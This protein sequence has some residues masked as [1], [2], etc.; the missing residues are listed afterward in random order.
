MARKIK[1]EDE[2][3]LPLMQLYLTKP[4]GVKPIY[5][6]ETVR[7][8]LDL[9][10]S[11][12]TLYKKMFLLRRL[13]TPRIER[14]WNTYSNSPQKLAKGVK[15]WRRMRGFNSA[16][17]FYEGV[18]VNESWEK[19]FKAIPGLEPLTP[20][21]L[22]LILDLYFRL[23]PITMNANTPEVAQLAKRMNIPASTV[24]QAMA[25]YQW[26]DPYLNRPTPPTQPLADA[27][28][29][30]WKRFVNDSAEKLAATASLMAQ[31]F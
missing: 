26:C 7:L 22:I 24:V 4:V 23:T 20:V 21:M 19:D 16:E 5:A 11:P 15:L 17:D 14:L 28:E 29:E 30:I 9:H 27:C 25:A 1:W 6:K 2:F 18:E 8:A 31:L 12:L 10:I 13:A 3:W